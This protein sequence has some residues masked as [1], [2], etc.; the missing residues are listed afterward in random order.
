M[1]LEKLNTT[2]I[3]LLT[4]LVSFVTSIATGI[5]TVALIEQAPEEVKQPVFNVVERTV[6]R[7]VPEE[8][9]VPGRVVTTEKTVIVKEEDA[10]T[11]AISMIDNR[12][13]RIH[14]VS[15]TE[16]INSESVTPQEFLGLGV[17]LG[18]SGR[19]LT[20]APTIVNSGVDRF[21]VVGS[22]MNTQHGIVINRDQTQGLAVLDSNLARPAITFA[23]S[24]AMR[25]GQTVIGV[26]GETSSVVVNGIVTSL[27]PLQVN[28][29]TDSPSMPVVNLFGELVAL[30]DGAG[31]L[32]PADTLTIQ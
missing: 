9:E 12:L 25:L 20:I 2:Q 18:E 5:A 26:A 3:V 14:A 16:P 15:P 27:T 23:D 29:N 17:I 32:V 13:V 31:N 11:D 21:V 8:I 24:T 22:G 19:I 7:V 30:T 1:D 6:E 4:L 28:F 10:V